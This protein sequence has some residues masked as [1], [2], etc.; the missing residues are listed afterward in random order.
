MPLLLLGLAG[1][2]PPAEPSIVPT[3]AREAL[4]L[5]HDPLVLILGADERTATG[6]GLLPT[7]EAAVARA[8]HRLDALPERGLDADEAAALLRPVADAGDALRLIDGELAR[9]AVAVEA[10][11]PAL[12]RWDERAQRILDV[13]WHRWLL[14]RDQAVRLADP[15]L[16]P[17]GRATLGA[18]LAGQ[19][20]QLLAGPAEAGPSVDSAGLL[21]LRDA[22]G[23]VAADDGIDW[24]CRAQPAAL[25]LDLQS[26][27][28]TELFCGQRLAP[29]DADHDDAGA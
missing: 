28:E 15:S 26:Y 21:Q 20:R 29:Y 3:A 22:L 13:V 10:E 11:D 6:G 8:I 7:A 9:L 1:C 18:A 27:R 16:D 19:L 23:Y 25:M 12:R 4:P 17:S 14:V 5:A 24:D 2:A